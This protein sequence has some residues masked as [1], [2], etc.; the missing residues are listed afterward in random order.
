MWFLNRNYAK[1]KVDM[2]QYVH[3]HNKEEQKKIFKKRKSILLLLSIIKAQ[4]LRKSIYFSMAASKYIVLI[5]VRHIFFVLQEKRT[6]ID[7]VSLIFILNNI[8]NQM[9]LIRSY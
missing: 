3:I 1:N 2:M 9:E 4:L 8:R 6:P 5:I 7:N